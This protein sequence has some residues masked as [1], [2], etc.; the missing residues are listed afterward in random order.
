LQK[1]AYKID[2]FRRDQDQWILELL[3]LL[4]AFS[5]LEDQLNTT[6]NV[7]LPNDVGNP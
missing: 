4:A 5:Q 1:L 3:E 6:V 2:G 7:D